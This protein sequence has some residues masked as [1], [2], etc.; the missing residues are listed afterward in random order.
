MTALPP[1]RSSSLTM[2]TTFSRPGAGGVERAVR[3]PAEAAQ[4]SVIEAAASA[5]SQLGH[6]AMTEPPESSFG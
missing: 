4:R 3:A 1:T 5:P 2:K 6:L